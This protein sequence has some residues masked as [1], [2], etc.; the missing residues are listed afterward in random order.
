MRFQCR[1][2]NKEIGF[3]GCDCEDKKSKI[4]KTKY[5]RGKIPTALCKKCK[6]N[7]VKKRGELCNDC[8]LPERSPIK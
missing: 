8:N 1:Y 5:D 4:W 3:F 7:R 6:F 2:C